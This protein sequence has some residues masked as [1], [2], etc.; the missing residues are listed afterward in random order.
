MFR[1]AAAAVVIAA[2]PITQIC[3][4]QQ[5]YADVNTNF[6]RSPT[7][8][9]TP[10]P[11]PQVVAGP[12]RVDLTLQAQTFEPLVGPQGPTVRP[13]TGGPQQVDLTQQAVFSRPTP[14]R[15][16]GV[17]PL[18]LAAPQ[19][20]PSQL[21]AQFTPTAATPPITP[22]PIAAFFFTPGQVEDRETRVIWSS[23]VSG[24]TPS[25]PPMV[26]GAPQQVDLTQQ[27][28]IFQ[29][30]PYPLLFGPVPPFV[31]NANVPQT[32]PYQIPAQFTMPMTFG[33]PPAGPDRVFLDI[34]SGRL[35]YRVTGIYIIPLT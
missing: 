7:S 28:Q 8:G 20:D 32:N 24:F 13:F 9:A 33:A 17:P 2:A 26:T 21:P 10:R 25:V 35:Y 14:S 5:A 6:I 27:G 22:N 29:A 15:Q 34:H 30:V 19:A 1:S 23:Q 11:I 31:T 16:G 3:V 12:Q 4:P 18:V